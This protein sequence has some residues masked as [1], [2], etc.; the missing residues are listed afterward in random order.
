MGIEPTQPAWK[1]GILPLNNTRVSSTVILYHSTSAL[2]IPFLN[3]FDIKFKT[4]SAANA[5]ETLPV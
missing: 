4:V 1:A 5:A 3:F 2:S